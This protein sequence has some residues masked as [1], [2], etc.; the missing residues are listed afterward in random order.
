MS[1]KQTNEYFRQYRLRNI[2]KKL[3]IEWKSN[4][5]PE[6]LERRR[7]YARKY[8]ARKKEEIRIKR[9]KWRAQFPEKAKAREVY[10]YARRTGRLVPK[11]CEV[12]GKKKVDGHHEDY[13]RPLVVKWLCR[14]HHGIAH[15]MKI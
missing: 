6:N 4:N 15:R 3:E 11:P 8:F 10:K 1:K 2:K 13:R 9:A 7:V 12:C 5:K 14:T